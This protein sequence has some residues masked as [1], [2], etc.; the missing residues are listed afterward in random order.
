MR[1]RKLDQPEITTTS[2]AP[3]CGGILSRT[4]ACVQNTD[5]FIS[6]IEMAPS[7][8]DVSRKFPNLSTNGNALDLPVAANLQMALRQKGLSEL[9]V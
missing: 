2:A 6:R 3:N 7:S 1:V 4:L 8:E 9:G 5:W